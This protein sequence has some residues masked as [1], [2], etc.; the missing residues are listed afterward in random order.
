MEGVSA[1]SSFS[2]SNINKYNSS[3]IVE[4]QSNQLAEILHH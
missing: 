2:A 3:Y 1:I 4:M